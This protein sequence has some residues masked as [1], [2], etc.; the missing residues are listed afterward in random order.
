[1]R[2]FKTQEEREAELDRIWWEQ[3]Q[4]SKLMCGLFIAGFFITL[5]TIPPFAFLILLAGLLFLF[6]RGDRT[7]RG[8]GHF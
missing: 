6:G 8:E 7:P 4:P 2:G 5:F 1:M 3:Q